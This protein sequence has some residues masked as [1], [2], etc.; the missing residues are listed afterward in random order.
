VPTPARGIDSLLSLGDALDN[1]GTDRRGPPTQPGSLRKQAEARADALAKLQPG[2]A[3]RKDCREAD[4]EQQVRQGGLDTQNGELSRIRTALE[5][6]TSK[7]FVL[8]DKAPAGKVHRVDDLAEQPQ[9]RASRPGDTTPTN[10]AACR[11]LIADDNRDA[12]DSLAQLLG[13]MGAEVEVAYDGASAL[14]AMEQFEPNAAV[15]DLGMP[16]MDGCDL[17][18][19]IRSHPRFGRILLVALSGWGQAED[20]LRTQRAGF[21]HH[22]VKPADYAELHHILQSGRA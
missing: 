3:R 4:R 19:R 16:G 8:P 5:R 9:A 2:D 1:H 15:L 22:L 13:L 18:S 10:L 6:S 17:A 11:V 21:D 7:Y 20:R 14:K 12:A